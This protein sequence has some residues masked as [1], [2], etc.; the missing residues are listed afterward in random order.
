MQFSR[1]V[2]LMSFRTELQ[3]IWQVKQFTYTSILAVFIAAWLNYI[4]LLLCTLKD[5]IMLH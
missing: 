3:I 4:A 1:F 5:A 2:N